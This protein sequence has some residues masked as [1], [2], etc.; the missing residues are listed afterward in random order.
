MKPASTIC[1]YKSEGNKNN[2]RVILYGFLAFMAVN[3]LIS[4]L[5]FLIFPQGLNGLSLMQWFQG[6]VFGLG[7]LLV[8]KVFVITNSNK[9]IF[10]LL[11]FT[12]ILFSVITLKSALIDD[13]PFNYLRDDL[14]TYFKY[15]FFVF[16]LCFASC[17]L[18]DHKHIKLALA[19]IILGALIDA[20]FKI[21]GYVQGAWISEAYRV[22]GVYASSGAVGVSG[23][24]TAGFLIT[25]F[26]LVWYVLKDHLWLAVL[27]SLFLLAGIYGTFDRTAQIALVIGL[28]WGVIW[29]I[30][31]SKIDFSLR[32]VFQ[33]LLL[34]FTFSFLFI[35]FSE[36][37]A[38]FISLIQDPFARWTY[39][40][41]RTGSLGSGRLIFYETTWC[42]FI[43]TD[44][45]NT[46]FGQGYSGTADMLY[47]NVGMAIH[48]HSDF[49]DLM[50]F[51]G[52]FGISLFIY[53]YYIIFKLTTGM[54][55]TSIEYVASIGI[56]IC[57]TVMCLFTGQFTA[58]HTML[59]FTIA[60]WCLFTISNNTSDN[61]EIS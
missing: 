34:I 9:H 15:V 50:S 42:W 4:Q 18:K 8:P 56:I 55:R 2:E 1:T 61:E 26:V 28:T 16:Y 45:L 25:A 46:L 39:E 31:F 38:F 10:K 36:N 60:L 33:I 6:F 22:A 44:F 3:P 43:N 40:L 19:C 57:F 11:F 30:I 48:T 20:G 53:F 24:A 13:V 52:I 37:E 12:I 54:P 47:K 49:F 35:I 21:F 17:I 23:K 51:G 59:S 41:D 5:G 27:I 32:N 29:L 7:L 14:I 58:P